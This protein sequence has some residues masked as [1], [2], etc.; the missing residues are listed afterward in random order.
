MLPLPMT[1]L[2]SLFSKM[3]MTICE[4]SGTSGTAVGVAGIGVAVGIS[5]AVGEGSGVKVG[6]SGVSVGDV[7]TGKQPTVKREAQSVKVRNIF[8]MSFMASPLFRL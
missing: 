4:K 7:K 8:V 1:V 5:V 2:Y 6:G 3:M